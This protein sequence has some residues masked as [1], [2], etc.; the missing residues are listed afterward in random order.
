M[1]CLETVESKIHLKWVIS[2]TRKI[3]LFTMPLVLKFMIVKMLHLTNLDIKNPEAKKEYKI[4]IFFA[5]NFKTKLVLLHMYMN[6]DIFRAHQKLIRFFL[7][8]LR[9]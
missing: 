1:I 7:F 4:V 2:K 6:I 3:E 9:F 8:F 5:Y